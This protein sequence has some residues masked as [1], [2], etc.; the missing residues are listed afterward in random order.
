[1]DSVTDSQNQNITRQ[2]RALFTSP[3]AADAAVE[4]EEVIQLGVELGVD[5]AD[6]LDELVFFLL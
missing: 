2:E 4:D 6:D 1:V 5:E 3:T